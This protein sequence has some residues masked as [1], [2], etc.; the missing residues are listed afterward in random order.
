MVSMANVLSTEKRAAVV[1]CLVEGLD[2]GDRPYDR[3]GE[4]HG[5]QAPG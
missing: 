4:E 3:R 5:D 2:P 1:R